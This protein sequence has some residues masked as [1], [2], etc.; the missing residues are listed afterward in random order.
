MGPT[1]G[2]RACKLY[3]LFWTEIED[4]FLVELLDFAIVF[5][6][7]N[8]VGPGVPFVIVNFV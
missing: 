1:E 2:R 4:S 5:Y 3:L 8:V 6:L 7:L